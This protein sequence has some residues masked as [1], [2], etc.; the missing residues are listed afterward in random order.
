MLDDAGVRR[1]IEGACR[2]A[3]FT[4]DELEQQARNCSFETENARRAWFM[5]TSFAQ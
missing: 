4:R 1:F 5:V 2:Q 3:G